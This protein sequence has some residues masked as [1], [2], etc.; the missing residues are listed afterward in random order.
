MNFPRQ[1]C[2]VNEPLPRGS[3]MIASM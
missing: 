2:R 1:M 3:C